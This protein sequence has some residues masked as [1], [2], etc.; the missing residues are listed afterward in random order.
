M[1]LHSDLYGGGN[2][3]IKKVGAD[4]NSFDARDALYSIQ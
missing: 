4:F 1:G 3:V 2:S